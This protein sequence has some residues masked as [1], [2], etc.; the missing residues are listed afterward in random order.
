MSAAVH[1]S[2]LSRTVDSSQAQPPQIDELPLTRLHLFVV[3]TLS[4]GLFCDSLELVMTNVLATVFSVDPA[5]SKSDVSYMLAA[6]FVGGAIG[7]PIIGRL[8]DV[9][10]RRR[11]LLAVIAA[12]G[13]LSLAC[14][15]SSSIRQLTV[16]RFF[17]GMALAAYLPLTW[18]YLAEVLP[19]F[20]RGR[21]AMLIGAAGALAASV[22]PLLTRLGNSWLLFGLEGWRLTL[23]IGGVG[24][25]L[26]LLMALRL[27]ESPKWLE[28]KGRQ[29]AAGEALARFLA[30]LPVSQTVPKASA[31]PTVAGPAVQ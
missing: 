16:L 28:R 11:T 8:A 13:I 31:S 7:A 10:G 23:S 3:L 9:Y 20:Y 24:G 21:M 12:Y 27:P 14:A 1:T 25:L 6:L 17:A 2:G 26:V 4:I 19:P 5:V 18:T 22:A 30:S 29:R 15:L